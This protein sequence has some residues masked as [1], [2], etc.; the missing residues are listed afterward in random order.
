MGCVELVSV[1]ESG[2]LSSCVVLAN[3]LALEWE[4]R[5]RATSPSTVAWGCE[6]SVVTFCPAAQQP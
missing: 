5:Q 1:G 4:R 3:C 6:K 2:E